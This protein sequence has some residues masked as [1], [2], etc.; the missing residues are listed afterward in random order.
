MVVMAKDM[1]RK[2]T[3]KELGVWLKKNAD[4]ETAQL[5]LHEK[6]RTPLTYELLKRERIERDGLHPLL[7]GIY[8]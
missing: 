2:V 3:F 4:S 7:D 6:K 5:F 1:A 8:F